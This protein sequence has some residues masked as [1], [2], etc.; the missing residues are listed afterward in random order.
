MTGTSGNARFTASSGHDPFCYRPQ[1]ARVRRAKR[2]GPGVKWLEL[3]MKS[4]QRFSC[5]PGQFIQ[6]SVFGYGEAPISVCAFQGASEGVELCVREAGNL[7]RAAHDLEPGDWAGIRG[8]FGR[9]FPMDELKGRNILVIAGGTGVACI[10]SLLQYVL[11]APEDFGRTALFYGAKT[12]DGLFF[13]DELKRWRDEDRLDL[14]LVVDEPDE[15]W[16]GRTG[17]V[18]DPLQDH[19]VK[20]PADAAAVVAGPPVMFPFA[21]KE[22]TSKKIREDHIFFTLERRFECGMGKCGHCQLDDLYVCRDGPVFRY[23]DLKGKSEVV[24][25][26]NAECAPQ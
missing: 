5:S 2:L 7:T 20:E 22:L 13:T 17:V 9:G 18:T 16:R 19:Y 14:S 6:L 10:R 11:K 15:T 4:E 26:G 23:T 8:P 24:E 1:T 12:P 25:T 21:F 3:T